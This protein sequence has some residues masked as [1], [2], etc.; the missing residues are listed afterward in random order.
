VEEVAPGH[1]AA[2]D[3]RRGVVGRHGAAIEM[4]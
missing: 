4:N 1:A 3:G 2:D